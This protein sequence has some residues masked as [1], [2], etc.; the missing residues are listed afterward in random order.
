MLTFL[1][2]ILLVSIG[3]AALAANLKIDGTVNV[4]KTSWNVHF[5]NVDIT[6]GSVTAN[7]APTTDE[8]NKNTTEIAYSM[9]FNKPGDFYEFTVDIVNS[10]TIDAMIDDGI[11]NGIYDLDGTTIKQQPAYLSNT[12]SYSDGVEIKKN[13]ILKANTS[14]TI[15]VRVAFRTDIDPSDLPKT[16]GESM[17]FILKATYKQADN[18]AKPVRASEAN[19]SSDSWDDVIAAYEGGKTVQLTEA[20]NNG[21][22]RNIDLGSLG[23]HPVRIANLSKCTNGE[24]SETS[25]GLVI[26]FADIVELRRMNPY[27]QTGQLGDGNKGGWEYS[28]LRE[29][30]NDTFYNLFPS[31]IKSKIIDT[32]VVSGHGLYSGEQNYNTTD[33]IY[34][35]S[36]KEVWNYGDYDTAASTTKQL[37]YYKNNGVLSYSNYSK[38]KK[39]YGSEYKF[40]WLRS[41]M[42][43]S[44]YYFNRVSPEGVSNSGEPTVS[45]GVSPAFRLAE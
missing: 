9:S 27:D 25:C 21:T 19:F 24:T 31:S 44:D 11:I 3:F 26:E 45:E 18:N 12:I 36:S 34:L 7:P 10:G 29:Y 14:E 38:T 8:V 28:E 2:L 41:V 42:N 22:T 6:P 13:Q 40:W 43:D 33:K 39:L 23:V 5:E 20:M 15:K 17:K 16:S 32:D 37:D 4:S 35:L 30:L 1:S